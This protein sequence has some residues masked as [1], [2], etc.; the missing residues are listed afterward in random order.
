ME[1]PTIEELER[2][3]KANEERSAKILDNLIKN[4][5]IAIKTNI[6]VEYDYK[7]SKI[8]RKKDGKVDCKTR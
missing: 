2:I 4:P 8:K 3:K 7:N 6:A 5:R 1:K